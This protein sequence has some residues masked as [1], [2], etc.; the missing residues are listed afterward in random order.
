MKLTGV[1]MSNYQLA[2]PD[3]NQIEIIY[4]WVTSE[5]NWSHIAGKTVNMNWSYDEYLIKLNETIKNVTTPYRIL[6]NQDNEVLGTIKGYNYLER[7][8]SIVIGFYIPEFNRNKG[9]GTKIV[10]LFVD[11]LFYNK[12]VYV[13]KVIATIVETNKGSIRILEKNEFVLEGELRESICVDGMRLT[14][15]YYSML[16]SEWDRKNKTTAS[17]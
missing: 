5:S 11:E 6:V 7:N 2:I 16:R 14:E 8:N 17:T 12:L 1:Y 10:E 13:N 3:D 4:K 15:Y 9:Y